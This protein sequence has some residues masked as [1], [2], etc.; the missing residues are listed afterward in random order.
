MKRKGKLINIW[1]N[2]QQKAQLDRLAE[3]THVSRSELVRQALD[4]LFDRA[5]GGQLSLGF[6]IHQSESRA[7]IEE[8]D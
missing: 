5:E 7:R 6:P 8:K 1:L 2:E 3:K 4:V